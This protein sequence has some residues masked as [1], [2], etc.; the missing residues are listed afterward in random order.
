MSFSTEN[1]KERIRILR[2]RH[3]NLD[4][5]VDEMNKIKNLSESEMYALK[6]LKL[7][8]LKCKDTIEKL[9]CEELSD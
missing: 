5:R 4:D 2:D 1:I 6:Q 9:I 3:Q 7:M 8:R